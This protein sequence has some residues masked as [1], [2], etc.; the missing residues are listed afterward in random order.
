MLLDFTQTIAA[1]AC[2]IGLMIYKYDQEDRLL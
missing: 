1:T 2:I